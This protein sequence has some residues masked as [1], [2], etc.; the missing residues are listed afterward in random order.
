MLGDRMRII[1][2]QIPNNSSQYL[3]F[4]LFSIQIR[5]GIRQNVVIH[6]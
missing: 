2:S 1:Y 3:R 4:L 5:N 6:N